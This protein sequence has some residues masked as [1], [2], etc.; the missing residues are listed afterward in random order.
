MALSVK[1][2]KKRTR[3]SVWSFQSFCCVIFS[4]DII[5]SFTPLLCSPFI[6]FTCGT[7]DCTYPVPRPL[8]S[9]RC[10]VCATVAGLLVS[11]TQFAAPHLALRRSPFR[12]RSGTSLLST[13]RLACYADYF[14]NYW[15]AARTTCIPYLYP[16]SAGLP[17]A[18]FRQLTRPS[19][20]PS[21]FPTPL[22]LPTPVAP[23]LLVRQPFFCVKLCV[24]GPTR[25]L[26]FGHE[27]C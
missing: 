25:L 6:R 18:C 24:S 23:V 3:H 8:P 21:L 1:M 16:P 9:R 20:Q 4:I 14:D 15:S 11:R 10:A 12:A 19:L 7:G 2:V 13:R 17:R 22:L 26:L 27:H 5:A